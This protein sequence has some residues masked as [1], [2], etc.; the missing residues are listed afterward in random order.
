MFKTDRLGLI[1]KKRSPDILVWTGV[2][3][4]CA[5]T[6][7]A[8][9]RGRKYEVHFEALKFL[10]EN[11]DFTDIGVAKE[12]EQY[13]KDEQERL[14]MKIM[15]YLE[16]YWPSA[17]LMLVGIGL[18]GVGHNQLTVRNA[19]IA[20]TLTATIAASNEYKSRVQELLGEH[21]ETLL[22]NYEFN[23]D[24]N[25]PE[26]LDNLQKDNFFTGDWKPTSIYAK[27]FDSSSPQWRDDNESNNYFLSAQQ[28]QANVTL[29]QRGHLFLN[30]VYDML[31]IP[32]TKAGTI[33]GWVDKGDG[34]GVVDFGLL[35]YQNIDFINGYTHGSILLDFNVDGVIWDLI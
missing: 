5:A 17:L 27:W 23:E 22:S 34:D 9:T 31:G 28:T 4:L 35:R 6:I 13:D 33:V 7:L 1:L 25:L 32:R 3:S 14:V 20:A 18:V 8:I 19:A 15:L 10:E 24:K 26:N 30:E 2:G 11:K 12:Y 21:G 16:T 29:R